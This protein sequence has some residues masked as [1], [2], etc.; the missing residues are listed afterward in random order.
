MRK[1]RIPYLLFPLLV[2]LMMTS[3]RTQKPVMESKKSE[4]EI[5]KKYSNVIGVSEKEI[6]NLQ[7]YEFL[8]EWMGTPYKYAGKNK[9]GIDCSGF[10]GILQKEVFSKTTQGT[11][12]SIYNQCKPVKKEELQ[13]GDLIFFKIESKV[14]S[15][16]GVYLQNN[17]FAHAAIK[18]GVVIDDLGETYYKKYFWSYGRLP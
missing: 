9:N 17:K 14:V 10:A 1:R 2:C 15:H 8:D 3:C 5:S 4:K 11:S 12:A 13:E 16:M 7:L 18:R 6:T